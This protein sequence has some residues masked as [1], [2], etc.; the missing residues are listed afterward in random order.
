M[1]IIYIWYVINNDKNIDTML[2]EMCVFSGRFKIQLHF[3]SGFAE[4]PIC[5]IE[6]NTY[7]NTRFDYSVTLFKENKVGEHFK[8]T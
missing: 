6:I 1:Y 3:F 8:I 4:N 5:G 7:F 2:R